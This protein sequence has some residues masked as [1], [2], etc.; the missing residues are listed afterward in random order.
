M[1][2]EHHLWACAWT[3]ENRH[4]GQARDFVK[5]GS[6]EIAAKRASEGIQIYRL[7][8]ALIRHVRDELERPRH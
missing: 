2:T 8:A 6:Q 3:I 4:G 7:I 5:Q 1:T